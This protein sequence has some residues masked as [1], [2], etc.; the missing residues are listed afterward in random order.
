MALVSGIVQS[1]P[2][3]VVIG[4]NRDRST[5][6][7]AVANAT[8]SNVAHIAGNSFRLTRAAAISGSEITAFDNTRNANHQID[9]QR[10]WAARRTDQREN[11]PAAH[12]QCDDSYQTAVSPP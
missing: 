2:W 5:N 4:I 1:N 9:N 7:T 8:S 3:R 6:S 10:I 12:H 11:Q